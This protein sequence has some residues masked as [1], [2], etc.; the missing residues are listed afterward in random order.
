M[1]SPQLWMN[2]ICSSSQNRKC[3]PPGTVNKHCE[4]YQRRT[5]EIKL[6]NTFSSFHWIIMA[7]CLEWQ[8][9]S[10]RHMVLVTNSHRQEMMFCP[11]QQPSARNT[12]EIKTERRDEACTNHV[13]RENSWNSRAFHLARCLLFWCRYRGKETRETACG[14]EKYYFAWQSR[15]LKAFQRSP[16]SL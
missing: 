13:I 14:K 11:L 4:K 7:T 8:A 9:I 5:G 1:W 3:C 16:S 15:H 6:Q 10:S 2:C 12:S